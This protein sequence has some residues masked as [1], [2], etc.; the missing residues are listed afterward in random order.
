[1]IAAIAHMGGY[2]IKTDQVKGLVYV[3]LAGDKA[4]D[5]LKQL[6]IEFGTK[7]SKSII[8][9]YVTGAALTK[10]NQAV[11]F[12]FITKAGTKGVVN[13]GK[14]VPLVGGVIG[15]SFDALSTNKIGNIARDCFIKPQCESE[16]AV[17][18]GISEQ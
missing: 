9:R 17:D 15:G 11:G 14:A 5:I 6:G 12:R 7:L 3:C 2:D 13:L 10:I 8:Q 18:D 1:M 4:K 16:L